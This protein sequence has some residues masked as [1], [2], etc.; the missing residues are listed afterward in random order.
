VSIGPLACQTLALLTC[1]VAPTFA[2][3]TKNGAVGVPFKNDALYRA[4]F[5]FSDGADKDFWG[6]DANFGTLIVER[7]AF[8]VVRLL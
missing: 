2:G 1:I 4:H 7:Y 8:R 6:Y 5:G 3:D